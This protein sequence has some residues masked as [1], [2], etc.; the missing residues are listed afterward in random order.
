MLSVNPR[1]GGLCLCRVAWTA[2]V[3]LLPWACS[4]SEGVPPPQVRIDAASTHVWDP[5]GPGPLVEAFLD[6]ARVGSMRLD[7]RRTSSCLSPSIVV[8]QSLPVRL[9]ESQ[10]IAAH[11]REAEGWTTTAL[12]FGDVSVRDWSPRIEEPQ[13]PGVVGVIGLDVLGQLELVLDPFVHEL[14]FVT[15][16]SVAG[17]VE[18]FASE[19]WRV[20]IL[21]LESGAYPG[22]ESLTNFLVGWDGPRRRLYLADLPALAQNR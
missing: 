8:S 22:F 16:G 13:Q 5:M 9:E 11:G 7:S 3:I 6:G 18:A 1:A 20:E 19:G 10:D 12:C 14:R 21:H 2:F 15:E 17:E 4:G